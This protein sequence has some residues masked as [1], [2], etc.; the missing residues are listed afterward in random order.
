M[1]Q[2]SFKSLRAIKYYLRILLGTKE[3]VKLW[4]NAYNHHLKAKPIDLIKSQDRGNIAL[5]V[6]YIYFI[7][8]F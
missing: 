5:V 7:G 8:K 3:N 4:L 1:N 2:R 6:S